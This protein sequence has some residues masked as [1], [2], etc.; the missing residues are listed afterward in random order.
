[1]RGMVSAPITN[2]LTKEPTKLAALNEHNV[3]VAQLC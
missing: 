1:M 3:P 2:D